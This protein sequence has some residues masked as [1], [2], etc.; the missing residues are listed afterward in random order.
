MRRTRGVAL[1]MAVIALCVAIAGCTEIQNPAN[2]PFAYNEYQGKNYEDI[3][4]ELEA[5]G[6][7]NIKTQTMLTFSE[8]KEYTVG[9]V[10]IDGN[11]T[12][13]KGAVYEATVPVVVSYYKL[14]IEVTM[15][16]T[17]GG[18]D[19]KP[20]FTVQTNLPDGTVL[21]AE[22]TGEEDSNFDYFEQRE[23]VVQGGTAVTEPFTLG[24]EPLVGTY[25]FGVV[26]FPAEQQEKVQETIGAEGEAMRGD[27]VKKEGDYWYAIT[28]TQYQSPIEAAVNKISEEE[29]DALLNKTLQAAFGEEYSIELEGYLY[30]VNLWH[31]GIA[32]TATLAKA[33]NAEAVDTW[34]SLKKSAM[35]MSVSLSELLSMNGHDDKMVSVNI[36]NDA[37]REKILLTATLGFATYDWVAE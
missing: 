2:A 33:G 21:N 7:Q 3:V 5:A 14:R 36:L 20:V 17:V 10:T 23:I 9:G 22:M 31:E 25:R 35:D 18:E 8:S 30:T 15:D 13:R 19:G 1:L 37:N 27:I 6:F 34:T 26:M 16:I 24:G 28:S 4:A 29:M 12:F 11:N 32:A